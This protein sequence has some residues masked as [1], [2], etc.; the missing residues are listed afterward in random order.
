GFAVVAAEVR[1][2]AHRS[3]TA[4]K[5]IGTLIDRSVTRINAGNSLVKVAGSAME[6]I[7]SSVQRVSQLV[8]TISMASGEQSSGIDQV[9]VAV[10][11]MDAATQQN[12]TL[13]QESSAAAISLEQQA[14]KLSEM[15]AIFK[16]S[17]SQVH[18]GEWVSGAAQTP[19][20]AVPSRPA[21]AAEEEWTS[22]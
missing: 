4:A 6:E 9:N 16:T 12:A 13:V 19:A 14:K 8:E 18:E 2:L 1:A 15:V 5:E 20:L 3:A 22:F 7:V 17:A 10:V 21:K 11:Q